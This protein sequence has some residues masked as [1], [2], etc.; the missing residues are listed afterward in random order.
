VHGERRDASRHG[1]KLLV[2]AVTHH[3]LRVE[4]T[5]EGYVATVIFDI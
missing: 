1:L 5:S 3:G 2:K 4:R